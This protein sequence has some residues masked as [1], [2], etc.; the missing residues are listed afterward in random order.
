MENTHQDIN[1]SFSYLTEDPKN[2]N[3]IKE[4]QSISERIQGKKQL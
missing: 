4:F 1:S 2:Y 3:D